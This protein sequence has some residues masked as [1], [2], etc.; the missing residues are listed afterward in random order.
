MQDLDT[1]A[2]NG[3]LVGEVPYQSR[4]SG[5]EEVLPVAASLMGAPGTNQ[6]LLQVALKCLQDSGRPTKVDT[7]VSMFHNGRTWRKPPYLEIQR[8]NLTIRDACKA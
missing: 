6:K 5:N 3:R 4:I 7:G 1:A 2:A 8:L